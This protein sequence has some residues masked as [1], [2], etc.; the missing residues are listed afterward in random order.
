[1]T[2]GRI[3]IV[4]VACELP[5]GAHTANNL[6]YEAV[7]TFLDEAKDAYETIPMDRFNIKGRHGTGPGQIVPDRGTF[8]KDIS[9]FDYLEFGLTLKDA[10]ALPLSARKLL[11]LSFNALTDAAIPYRG[12]RVGCFMAGVV[13]DFGALSDYHEHE[14]EGTFAY[15]PS[16]LA[17]RISYHLDLRGPSVSLDTACSST[18]TAMHLALESIAKGECEA[19]VVGGCQLNHRLF[20]WIQYSHA[21]VLSPDGMCK[22]FDEHADGFSR[23]EGAVV[24]VIK[25]LQRAVHDRDRVYANVL[26][27]AILHTGSVSPVYAPV[28]EAQRQAMLDAYA[29]TG[30]EPSQVDFVEC[31]ATGTAAGDP[32]EANWVGEECQREDAVICGSV[33]G[34]FGHTEAVAF[35]VSVVKALHIFQRRSIPP[36]VNLAIPNSKIEWQK[37]KIQVPNET[38]SLPRHHP[39]VSHIGISSWGIGGAGGHVVLQEHNTFQTASVFP[40]SAGRPTLLVTGALSPRAVASINSSAEELIRLRSVESHP[41]VSLSFGRRALQMPWRSFAI[42]DPSA[43]GKLLFSEP[44]FIAS[45]RKSPVIFVF[46]GQGPQHIHMGRQM[47]AIYPEFRRSIL[48]MDRTYKEVTGQSLVDSFRLFDGN[49]ADVDSS[50]LSQWEVALPAL[51]MVQMACYDLL[52]SFGVKPDV[53]LGHSAGETA[54]IYASGAGPKD[55]ALKV[56][57]ARAKMMESAERIGGTMLAL[58]CSVHIA[59]PIIE[60]VL[61]LSG[62]QSGAPELVVACHN[63]QD[64]VTVSG[65][66]PLIDMVLSKAV[67]QGILGRKLN[68]PVPVHSPL[69]DAVKEHCLNSLTEVFSAYPASGRPIVPTYSTVTGDVMDEPFT[70]EYFWNNAR[71]PVL[72]EEVLR[73]ISIQGVDPSFVEISPHPVLAS[74]IMSM[75]F[76]PSAITCALRRSRKGSPSLEAREF[77]GCLGCLTTRGVMVDLDAL[78]DYPNPYDVEYPVYPF[79]KKEVPYHSEHPSFHKRF[80]SPNGPLNC[81]RIFLNSETH[82]LLAQHVINNVPIMP[83]AGFIEMGL[84]FG[85]TA[86]YDVEFLSALPLN[87]TTPLSVEVDTDGGQWWVKTSSSLTARNFTA[88]WVWKGLLSHEDASECRPTLDLEAIRR[89]CNLPFDVQAIYEQGFK[90]YASFSPEYRRILSCYT[91]PGQALVEVRGGSEFDDLADY[92][93]HPVLL[94]SIFHSCMCFII[95]P[96]D[97][98]CEYATEAFWLPSKAA[99]VGVQDLSPTSL[100]DNIFVHLVLSSWS[101]DAVVVDMVIASPTGRHIC[102]ITGFTMA[103]HSTAIDDKEQGY[104]VVWQPVAV[105]PIAGFPVYDRPAIK[106]SRRLYECLDDL[107]VTIIRKSLEDPHRVGPEIHRERYM[108]FAMEALQRQTTSTKVDEAVL[109]ELR[110]SYPNYFLITDKVAKIHPLI[111][112]SHKVTVEALYSDA[113][114]MAAFYGPENTVNGACSD[115]A[116]LFRTA[117]ETLR[118]EGKKVVRVL[119]VGCGTGMLTE[120]ACKVAQETSGILTEYWASDISLGLAAQAAGRAK[121]PHVRTAQLDITRDPRE[122]GILLESFDV[123]LGLHVLHA[124]PD[125]RAALKTINNLLVPGGLLIITDFDGRH[126]LQHSP[127][128]LWYDFLFGS[129]AEWFNYADDRRHCTVPAEV[130]RQWLG[131]SGMRCVHLRNVPAEEDLSLTF[132]AQ[133]EPQAMLD[134]LSS[135]PPHLHH[136]DA[137]GTSGQNGDGRGLQP[138]VHK[139]V[140]LTVNFRQELL[141]QETIARLDPAETHSLWFIATQGM[142]AASALGLTRSLRG[143][144]PL[145]DIHLV[146]MDERVECGDRQLWIDRLQIR[147]YVEPEVELLLDGSLYV[148]RIV[149]VE[150]CPLEA[151]SKIKPSPWPWP[152]E[153]TITLDIVRYWNSE[154]TNIYT[155]LGRVISSPVR[156]YEAGHYVIAVSCDPPVTPLK[157]HVGCA[158]GAEL[159]SAIAS[160]DLL[161]HLICILAFGS[162]AIAQPGRLELLRRVLVKTDGTSVG[163]GIVECLQSLGIDVYV[164]CRED[165]RDSLKHRFN[166]D[167]DHV[168]DVLP[169]STARQSPRFDCAIL[170]SSD[171]YLSLRLSRFMSKGGKLYSWDGLSQ[172][173]Q[174][175]PWVIGSALACLDQFIGIGLWP[176]LSTPAEQG[177][178]LAELTLPSSSLFSGEKTYLLLGGIGGI[179]IHLAF[180]MSQR[181]ARHIVLTSRSG[182]ERLK[183]PGNMKNRRIVDFLRSI[184]GM[185]VRLASV[186][187]TDKEQMR[188]LIDGVHGRI[189]G[190][191]LL[192]LVLS[193]KLFVN[194]TAESFEAAASPKISAFETISSLIDM[195]SL[196]FFLSFSSVAALFGSPGQTNYTC[197]STALEGMTYKYPNALSISVPGIRDAG[198]VVRNEAQGIKKS[199]HFLNWGI[200]MRALCKSVEASIKSVSKD[201]VSLYIPQLS[202]QDVAAD[203]E[204]QPLFGHLPTWKAP[205][206]LEQSEDGDPTEST[207]THILGVPASDISDSVPLTSYGLDSLMAARM[208]ADLKARLGVSISQLELLSH[209]SVRDLREIVKE[210]SGQ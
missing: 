87:S 98:V 131:E 24:I 144:F 184:P 17:N 183:Q 137:N 20:D 56:A 206:S 166:L 86:L 205:E 175:E 76:P 48:E 191:F 155:Y 116:A 13:H 187:A 165:G 108:K 60:E 59:Q 176:Q 46:S 148:P 90:Q 112:E 61:A 88:P 150:E 71:C 139:P 141:L 39:E 82:P 185:D 16:M 143:E 153:Q 49:E 1:M 193:D 37:Y 159:G 70:P 195:S 168:W 181:G 109:N 105:S 197:A 134:V 26:G 198:W 177:P 81:P 209:M 119:E 32:T 11:E 172:I 95:D 149:P 126:W 15:I 84:E 210:R 12:R 120:G 170:D 107:A 138:S 79:Q 33:K 44:H 113:Q 180:W 41:A 152:Q 58:S 34:N 192:T 167:S 54:L 68:I 31:H 130:W 25:P 125:L 173:I 132:V 196:D 96:E 4:G 171:S 186:D 190:C 129:F 179:G 199:N 201:K 57:I 47:Y 202:W 72:F 65:L 67:E 80:L 188:Q 151:P 117:L 178:N 69:M 111:F 194:Q 208:S 14:A 182:E 110:A 145:W 3:A 94:D 75:G 40:K 106:D 55:L 5:S 62:L 92:K 162:S 122:Q 10:R 19:A 83:A 78:N 43:E 127:G 100:K 23:G 140:T 146:I 128:T 63:S 101:P 200:T 2:D 74:Y 77:L 189:G 36:N 104:T 28:A 123:I 157:V 115:N 42:F 30:V 52:R 22:P 18:F 154:K 8:L 169:V 207:V 99:Y 204:S 91:G 163:A 85:A 161:P 147:A 135:S 102:S 50:V 21:S 64:A 160:A 29:R 124:A 51:T 93:F 53:V 133:K 164:L 156:S 38:V 118:K 103:R 142:D 89:D 114:T 66:R 136:V 121:Y 6:D 158:Y 203:I 9:H 73:R 35:L 7:W 27:S 174:D 45:G 97:G